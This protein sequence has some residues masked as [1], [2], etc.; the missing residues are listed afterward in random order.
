MSAVT[1]VIKKNAR[2]DNNST[3]AKLDLRE[4]EMRP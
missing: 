1:E 3:P 2:V 4:R